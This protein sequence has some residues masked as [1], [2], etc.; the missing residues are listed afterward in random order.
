MAAVVDRVDEPV[1]VGVERG[2]R[3]G[4]G[5]G[6]RVVLGVRRQREGREVGV[7]RLLGDADGAAAADALGTALAR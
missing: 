7:E 4:R 5:D 6:E 3:I 1:V 2:V